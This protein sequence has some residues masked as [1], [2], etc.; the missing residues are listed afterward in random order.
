MDKTFKEVA[1][2]QFKD[3]VIKEY[4]D[5]FKAG[6]YN[7]M[8]KVTSEAVVAA[9]EMELILQGLALRLLGGEIW[10][11]KPTLEAFRQKLSSMM[12]ASADAEA[13]H[14]LD[15]LIKKLKNV[16][17][18][19]NWLLHTSFLE[20][21]GKKIDTDKL[22]FTIARSL[23]VFDCK[24]IQKLEEN[25]LGKWKDQPIGFNREEKAV[26][27]LNI[28]TRADWVLV[29]AIMTKY[30]IYE[31]TDFLNNNPLSIYSYK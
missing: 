10:G 23:K 6:H 20:F 9:Q 3:F 22:F 28:S 24:G 31:L 25:V 19:R 7:S 12:S 18:C 2:E 29:K 11:S 5:A 4:D 1:E 26:T 27:D 17:E 16:V 30:L 14:S 13:V 21:S 8:L 15:R